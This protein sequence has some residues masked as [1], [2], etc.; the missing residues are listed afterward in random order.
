L[1][2]FQTIIFKRLRFD[3]NRI[4]TLGEKIV[5]ILGIGMDAA[6]LI[7]SCGDGWLLLKAEIDDLFN[8]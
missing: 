2:L 7:L 6:G 3:Q 4:Q 8:Y 5:L 1:E